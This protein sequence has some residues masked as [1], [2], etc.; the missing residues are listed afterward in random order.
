MGFGAEVG[1]SGADAPAGFF[2]GLRRFVER[3]RGSGADFVHAEARRRGGVCALDLPPPFGLS[4]SKPSL[5]FCF[6]KGRKALRQA[7]GER[8]WGMRLCEFALADAVW[9]PASAGMTVELG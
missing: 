1:G 6:S 5:S 7:Q 3:R 9:I 4:S 8:L 2:P